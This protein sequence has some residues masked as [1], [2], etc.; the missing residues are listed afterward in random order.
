M[1][2]AVPAYCLLTPQDLTHYF[3]E[4]RAAVLRAPITNLWLNSRLWLPNLATET[5][6]SQQRC[7]GSKQA[8]PR[9]IL[10]G[11]GLEYAHHSN[12]LL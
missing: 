8:G 5:R 1:K 3:D 10:A 12:T 7:A 2:T 6:D 11:I 4:R 9:S